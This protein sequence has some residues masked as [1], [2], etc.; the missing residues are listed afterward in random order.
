MSDKFLILSLSNSPTKEGFAVFWREND[1]GYTSDIL[2]AGVYTE[3]QIKAS[4][5]YNNG[6]TT[7]AIPYE[8]TRCHKRTMTVIDFSEAKN[9]Q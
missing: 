2:E 3:E 6:F 4:R 8:K 5:Y 7:K 9:I 1:S